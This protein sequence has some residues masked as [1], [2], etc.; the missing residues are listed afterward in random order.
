[1]KKSCWFK[2]SIVSALLVSSLVI[3]SCGGRGGDAAPGVTTILNET[4]GSYNASNYTVVGGGPWSTADDAGNTVMQDT[5][6]NGYLIYDVYPDTSTDYTVSVRIKPST[7]TPFAGVIARFY[8]D[9]SHYNFYTLSIED[10]GSSNLVLRKYVAGTGWATTPVAYVGSLSTSTWY[11][12]TLKVSGN[13]ITGTVTDG[14]TTATISLNDDGT[15]HGAAIASGQ[16]GL[17]DLSST[18]NSSFDGKYQSL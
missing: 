7:S 11:T 8:Y 14:V 2:M 6:N 4:F 16:A 1:M 15:F 12:I 3:V 10:T 17:I 13:M 18:F 5:S 9:G